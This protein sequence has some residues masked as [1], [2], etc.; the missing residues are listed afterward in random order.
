MADPPP[1]P[2]VSRS[3]KFL[4]QPT[5]AMLTFTDQARDMVRAF[6]DQSEGELAYLRISSHGSPMA[7]QFELTLVS[8]EERESTEAEIELDGFTVLIPEESVDLLRD[9]T[10]DFVQRVNESGFEVRPSATPQARKARN[11]LSR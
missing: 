4:R 7:P 6:I 5:P 10:V 11:S 3:S 8:E 9:A 1:P 2:R